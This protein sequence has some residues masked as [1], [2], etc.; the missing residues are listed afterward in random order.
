MRKL[1][2]GMS[3]GPLVL[4]PGSCV[5]PIWIRL[6]GGTRLQR[7]S[8]QS[9]SSRRRDGSREGGGAVRERGV[10]ACVQLWLGVPPVQL[11]QSNQSSSDLLWSNSEKRSFLLIAAGALGRPNK[12]GLGLI[13]LPRS[14][15]KRDRLRGKPCRLL[16]R[17]LCLTGQTIRSSPTS[18]PMNLRSV[19]TWLHPLVA[20]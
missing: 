11:S 19:I 9:C 12:V 8:W 10:R 14:A 6:R 7:R 3:N 15:F 1:R 16:L 2:A 13:H 5:R 17:H 20:C 4:G 18:H